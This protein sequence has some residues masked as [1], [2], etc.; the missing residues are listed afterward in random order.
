MSTL[1]RK[2]IGPER[3]PHL[4]SPLNYFLEP[5]RP[6]MI[7]DV[8]LAERN[9][10]QLREAFGKRVDV[11]YAV[12][13]NSH[14]EVLAALA[15]AGAG[16]DIASEGELRQLLELRVRGDRMMFSN[17]VKPAYDI[18][19]AYAAGVRRYAADSSDEIAKLAEV[20]P[21]SDVYIRLSVPNIGS[22]WP[23]SKK[24]GVS[25]KE[26]ASLCEMAKHCGLRPVGFTF[27]VGSQCNNIEN[28]EAAMYTASDAWRKAIIL[29]V[30]TLRLLNLGGG[31]SAPYNPRQR[32]LTPEEVAAVVHDRLDQ[33]FPGIQELAIESGRFIVAEAGTLYA[34]VTLVTERNGLP[35]AH[36]DVGLYNG[37]HECSQGIWYPI[38]LITRSVED[39][40]AQIVTLAG[41]SCDSVDIIRERL[42]FKKLKCDDVIAFHMTG[43]YTTSYQSYNG[44]SFPQVTTCHN[45]LV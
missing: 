21:G 8:P 6:H 32:R 4:Q 26:A 14:P 23:L 2:R 18:A 12:K 34:N 3:P 28:W 39:R 11:C 29:G 13:A 41:P 5:K 7:L 43:A 17:P 19:A 20:A 38:Q 37:L 25:A 35:M 15:Q 9:F 27:H 40:P 31:I 22:G 16:F 24:F 10:Y 45:R 30:D 44:Q 1:A 42:P 36:L 33:R